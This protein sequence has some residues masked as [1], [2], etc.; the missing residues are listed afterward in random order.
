MYERSGW[1]PDMSVA[2]YVAELLTAANDPRADHAAISAQLQ[3]LGCVDVPRGG[4]KD[5]L[6]SSSSSSEQQQQQQQQGGGAGGTRGSV[7]D[8][9][10][11]LVTVLAWEQL[12]APSKIIVTDETARESA[13]LL[14]KNNLRRSATCAG[15][16]ANG[17][18]YLKA[19]LLECMFL[20]SPRLKRTS[21]SCIA[22]LVT[23][24][25]LE[26]WPELVGILPRFICTGN[27][28]ALDTLH[29][30][31]EESKM[32][33]EKGLRQ[34]ALWYD[35]RRR[36]CGH[37]RSYL[38]IVFSLGLAMSNESRMCV[39]VTQARACE[40]SIHLRAQDIDQNPVRKRMI[41]CV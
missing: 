1:K 41:M 26:T 4:G 34:E 13:G 29:E 6:S 3:A 23:V 25:G 7:P 19:T 5:A 37:A 38:H 36:T 12:W 14:L 8:L 9:E 24:T 15:M 35:T 40:A 27:E 39:S 16:S 32:L 11:Y 21:S 30:I 2:G 22:A 31:L 10:Q 17:M 33:E 28:T 18:A 20:P